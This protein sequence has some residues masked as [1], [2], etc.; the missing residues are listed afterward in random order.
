M[1]RL[2]PVPLVVVFSRAIV[3]PNLTPVGGHVRRRRTLQGLLELQVLASL[4]ERWRAVS[5]GDSWHE[6]G[7]RV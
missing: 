1:L 3:N 5:V 2:L 6:L 4:L 7:P